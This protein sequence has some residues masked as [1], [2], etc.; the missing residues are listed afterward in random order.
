M[1]E[2][3]ILLKMLMGTTMTQA[4]LFRFLLDEKLIDRDRLMAFLQKQGE[5]WG[6]N[7]SDV[8]LLPL[9]VIKTALES[10][11]EPLFPATFH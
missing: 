1:S 6:K 10:T 9:V 11:E 5:R 2:T 3:D 4:A 8:E 7:A